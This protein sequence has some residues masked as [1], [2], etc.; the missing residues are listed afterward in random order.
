MREMLALLLRT[1]VTNVKCPSSINPL[2]EL[3]TRYR[4][5]CVCG[6]ADGG[7][8]PEHDRARA[9]DRGESER[10]RCHCAQRGP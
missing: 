8:R 9:G 2:R 6:C 3:R 4:A 1:S 7:H 10:L 5:H